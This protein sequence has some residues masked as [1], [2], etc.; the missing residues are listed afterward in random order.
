MTALKDVD[1]QG[2]GKLQQLEN[3][4][5]QLIQLEFQCKNLNDSWKSPGKVLQ[6][7]SRKRIRTLAIPQD[8]LCPNLLHTKEFVLSV[9]RVSSF[10]NNKC[11][12]MLCY[13]LLCSCAYLW[14]SH[15]Y[16]FA[17]PLT[18]YCVFPCKYH[19]DYINGFPLSIS[20]EYLVKTLSFALIEFS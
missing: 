18:I 15:T 12:I 5:S 10:K 7:C 13:T 9:P 4:F 14:I 11:Y 16:T 17:F 2:D 19:I 20:L 8:C 1:E 6:N 3:N